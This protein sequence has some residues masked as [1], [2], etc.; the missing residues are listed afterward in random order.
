VSEELHFDAAGRRLVYLDDYAVDRNMRVG[1]RKAIPENLISK[2]DK[3]FG[4]IDT[5]NHAVVT[6]RLNTEAPGWTMS[7]PQFMYVEGIWIKPNPKKKETFEPYNDGTRHI[8]GVLCSM[9]IGSVTRWE[10]GESGGPGDS[11]AD[12]AK[13]AMSDWIKRAAMRFGVGIELW[14]KQDMPAEESS[15]DESVVTSSDSP[16]KTDDAGGGAPAVA[17]A[18]GVPE[19]KRADT[20]TT[21][22]TKSALAGADGSDPDVTTASLGGAAADTDG[23]GPTRCTHQNLTAFKPDNETPY[24]DGRMRCTDC[25]KTSRKDGTFA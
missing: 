2:V 15:S 12:E 10:V 25:G 3:G 14:T 23:S 6:D 20:S 17:A 22:A 18:A 21:P 19:G 4:E 16:S 1:L 7:E 5:I 24:A 8:V 11:A 9:T 13:K